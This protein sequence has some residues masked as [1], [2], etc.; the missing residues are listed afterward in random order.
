MDTKLFEK[1]YKKCCDLAIENKDLREKTGYSQVG[2]CLVASSG[3]MYF[4][5][6]V[7][8]WHSNCAEVSALSNAWMN[9]E[10]KMRYIMAVK[11][12]KRNEQLESVTPCG[13]CREMLNQLHPEVKIVYVE[14]DEFI[15]KTLDEMLPDIS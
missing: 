3:K 11:F 4:G 1:M 12:N 10:R 2:C 6:N 14:N 5:L 13:I 8:W 7:G 9:G 15:V